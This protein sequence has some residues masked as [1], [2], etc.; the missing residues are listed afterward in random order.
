MPR[1]AISGPRAERMRR[2]R[3][4]TRIDGNRIESR[5]YVRFLLRGT[6]AQPGASDN[7][8]MR[9]FAPQTAAVTAVAAVCTAVVAACGSSGSA[10]SSA[11]SSGAS[12]AVKA[13][14]SGCV[15]QSQA[16]QIWTAIDNRI[17][18]F[19]ADPKNAK[20]DTIA[21]GAGLS[22]VQQYLARQLVAN[23]WTEREVDKL[24]SLTVVNA[25]CN[26]GTL[27]VHGT[28]TL[29]TDEYVAADG[30]VDHHDSE[31]GSQQEFIDNYVRVGGFWK[32]SQLQNPNQTGPTPPPQVI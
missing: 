32:Q 25:G 20:P 31:E 13:Q 7:D 29:V 4:R 12:G 30:T 28:I 11:P 14:G 19:E 2:G 10:V 15:S 9:V 8:R 18:A 21:T 27:I 3:V 23:H 1:G 26:N 16:Q 24:D 17:I 5:A 22:A 6:G